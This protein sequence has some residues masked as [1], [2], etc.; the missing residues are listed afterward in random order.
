MR[1][2]LLTLHICGGITGILSGAAA[3]TFRKGSRWHG[4]VGNMF[5]IAMLAMGSSGS[6]LAVMKHEMNNV[7]GGILACYL[8]T[9][10]WLTA[11]RR[12][13]ERNILDWIALAVALAAGTGMLAFGFEAA[14]S[15][16]GT[17]RGVPAG[18]FFFLATV[19]L[20]AAAGDIRMLARGGVFGGKR[21]VRHLWRMCFSFFVATGSFF[22]GQQQVFPAAWRG[23]AVW[24]VP[25]LLPLVL[26]IFW[27]F[28]VWFTKMYGTNG[29]RAQ[30]VS[31]D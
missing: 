16:S 2:I 24:F 31:S 3:M 9:T 1:L 29:A 27:L 15:P 18:M 20:L 4:I 28:R 26:L 12:D 5:V 10:A 19:V 6:T 13:G 30:T 7:F 17:I 8:V 25:A 14:R 23:A 11:R 21:V 22:L